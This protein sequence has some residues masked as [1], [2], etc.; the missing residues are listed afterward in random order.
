MGV[1][2]AS[3]GFLGRKVSQGNLETASAQTAK[4]VT[5]EMVS[6]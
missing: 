2:T 4:H 3:G 1:Q 6:V 5:L